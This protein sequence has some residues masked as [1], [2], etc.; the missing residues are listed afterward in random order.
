MKRFLRLALLAGVPWAALPLADAQEPAGAVHH[1]HAPAQPSTTLMLAAG[2]RHVTLSLADLGAMP[3][4]SVTV[5]NGH[6]KAE[7]TYA[8]PLVS[9]VLAKAGVILNSATEHDFL[10]SYVVATGTD[11]Y[12]VV[13]SGAELQGALHKAQCIVAITKA[14]Q[15]L[16]ENG[17]FQLVDS[18]DAKPARW[19]RNLNGLSVMPV[20]RAQ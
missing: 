19:V 5:L 13:F 1:V 17:A 7:E 15:P 11:G 8:G 9:D 3:Q 14:G 18:L 6:T 12:F 2:D 10:H 4:V 20:A 16:G